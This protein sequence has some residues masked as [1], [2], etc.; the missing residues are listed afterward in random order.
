MSPSLG[1][2]PPELMDVLIGAAIDHVLGGVG[3]KLVAGRIA[4]RRRL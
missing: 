4:G 2:I 1:C 3:Y